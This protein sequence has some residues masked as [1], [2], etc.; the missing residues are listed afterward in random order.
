MRKLLIIFCIIIPGTIFSQEY[1]ETEV[2]P[3][4]GKT[5]SE[6][7][8]KAYEWFSVNFNSA[9]E[10]IQMH[11]PEAN[12]IVG[13]GYTDVQYNLR[14]QTVTMHMH[15]TLNV[16]FRDGRYKYEITPNDIEPEIGPN[17][18]TYDLLKELTTEEGLRD[19]FR[20][21]NINTSGRSFKTALKGNRRC[22]EEVNSILREIPD[23]LEKALKE[24]EEDW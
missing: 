11:D 9:N 18:Y 20:A 14:K 7:Y 1:T 10:V 19:Y 16:Q 24:K 17:V 15:F 2:I 22:I 23:R 4:K 13:K 8:T 6:L 5:A 21:N 12:Q 3:V